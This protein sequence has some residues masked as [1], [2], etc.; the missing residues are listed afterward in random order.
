MNE[1]PDKLQNKLNQ[2]RESN[3]LRRLTTGSN[4]IDF[5]SNDYLGFSK[6]VQIAERARE[7]LRT[8]TESGQG[9]AGSRLLTGNS[10]LFQRAEKYIADFHLSASAL[11]FN[12][13]YTANLG[14][15]GSVPQRGDFILYD[16]FV[17]ASIREA[18]TL[19]RAK[20]F[21]FKHNDLRSL[22]EQ[23]VRLERL[24][25][26]EVYV[27]TESVFSMDGDTPDLRGMAEL[28]RK[29]DCR[30]ILDEAHAIGISRKGLAVEEG[31]AE[32]VF[33]RIVTFGKALGCHGAAVL[34]SESLKDYLINFARSFIYTTALPPHTV[35]TILAAY[36]HL[37]SDLGLKTIQ[38]L[39]SNIAILQLYLN[40]NKLNNSFIPSE[41]A[42]HS[43]VISGNDRVKAAAEQL[44]ANGFDIKPIL[45]PTVPLSRERL[46]ICLH[47]YNS[48]DEIGEVVERLAIFAE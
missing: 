40:K 46:R 25:G 16:E 9:S 17:H 36:E 44:A 29:Y 37:D 39:K 45:S 5:S 47:S 26:S 8:Y 28:C 3:S 12:S 19:S 41:T 23:M 38:M 13:G 43:M 24:E 7:I 4:L 42:I 15:L 21:K 34:G 32:Y 14:L 1:L 30:M 6:N 22:E 48:E 18:I 20:A 11:I 33:A 35:A 2:R 31:I 27:V 10:E